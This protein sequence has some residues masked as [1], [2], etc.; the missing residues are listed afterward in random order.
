MKY[1][2]ITTFKPGD[3]DR[4]ARRMVQSVIDRWPNVDI[5]VYYCISLENIIK[6]TQLLWA[7]LIRYR[8]VSDV[9]PG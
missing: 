9:H 3:W 4:Y 8:E 2:V 5:T 6:T 1:K 7:N